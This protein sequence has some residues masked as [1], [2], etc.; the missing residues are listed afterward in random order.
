MRGQ[1]RHTLLTQKIRAVRRLRARYGGRFLKRFY[2]K[3]TF[4]TRFRASTRGMFWS[5]RLKALRGIPCPMVEQ[6][7]A[8][9]ASGGTGGTGR[10]GRIGIFC[11]RSVW[12]R[13]PLILPLLA[14]HW[15]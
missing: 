5:R 13:C 1:S 3:F 2:E 4:I 14:P 7:V 12:R 9:V 6:S 15:L 8:S 10:D 11:V